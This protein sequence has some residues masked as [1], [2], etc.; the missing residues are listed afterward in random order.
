[1]QP[2]A[3]AFQPQ[4]LAGASQHLWSSCAWGCRCS[5]VELGSTQCPDGVCLLEELAAD[6]A[7]ACI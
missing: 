3:N 7:G 6:F 5:V 1:M 4:I 2:Q